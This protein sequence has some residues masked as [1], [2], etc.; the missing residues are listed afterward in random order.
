MT[1]TILLGL[2]LLLVIA[3]YGF[4]GTAL[5]LIWQDLRVNRSLLTQGR[6]P[7]IQV[8]VQSAGQ[9]IDQMFHLPEITIGRDP[10]STCKL[11]SETVSAQHARLEHHH[12]QWWLEDLN[13]RNGTILNGVQI[14][15]PTVVTTG[16]EIRCGD[17]ILTIGEMDRL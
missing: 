8:R 9:S 2:R 15:E 13:S 7:T 5:Y 11:T 12:K 1:A 17:V 16:D 6:H 3:L 4:L 10:A 14:T